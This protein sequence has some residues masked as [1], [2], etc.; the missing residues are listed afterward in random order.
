[1]SVDVERDIPGATLSVGAFRETV[2]DQLVTLFGVD[3]PF[4]P[5]A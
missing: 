5:S 3:L 4:Q 1:M 2:A